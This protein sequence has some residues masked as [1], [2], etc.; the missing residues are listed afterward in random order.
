MLRGSIDA[1]INDHI[2]TRFSAYWM[3]E[4]GWVKNLSTGGTNNG[5]DGW[6]VRGAVSIDITSNLTW[7]VS[8]D[9]VHDVNS[10]IP[11]T[12]VNGDWVSHSA[13]GPVG[14]YVTGEKGTYT[15]NRVWNDTTGFTSKFSLASTIGKISVITGYRHLITKYNLDYFDKNSPLGGYDSIE[16]SEHNQFSQEVNVSGTGL[17]DIVDYTVGAFFFH[18]WNDSDFATLLNLTTPIVP[19]DRT[20]VNTTNSF[21]VYGQFDIHFA[22]KMT[23]T[24]GGRYTADAKHLHYI[25][26]NNPLVAPS[27]HVTDASLLALGIPLNQSAQVFTPRFA[28]QYEPNRD[29][30]FYASATKGFKSGGWNIRAATANLLTNFANETIW[31]Y[32]AGMRSQW[33]DRRVTFNLTGFYGKTK[34]FQIATAGGA[35][36]TGAP[37]FPVGNFSD[38]VSKGIEAELTVKPVHGL[39]LF[40]N[41]GWDWTKYQNPT[42]AVQ[43][44][45]A[46]CLA[47]L[48]YGA[49]VSNA[50]NCGNG[51][52]TAT[53]GI[54]IPLRAPKFTGTVGFTYELALNRDWNLVPTGSW[55][56]VSSFNVNSAQLANTFDPGYDEFFGSI[57]LEN[58]GR[59]LRFSVGCENCTNDN[60]LISVISG[61]K[62]WSPPRRITGRAAIR[63]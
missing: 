28:L 43:A 53:G 10:M 1:P 8:V 5:H 18:E 61:Y 35:M 26:N 22:P 14:S 49:G 55:R 6:G 37:V 11:E 56:H 25:D 40:T 46:A 31:S 54:A 30:T 15:G 41:G 29:L 50:A 12:L 21:A 9:H 2:R 42:P 48:Q 52:V 47:Y 62:Y 36:G 4:D 39:S 32:E 51:I 44:Q 3:D 58:P 20:Y 38:F 16:D 60:Y 23:L 7:D 13:L 63:F 57:G 24:L 59:G 34:N 33:L 17:H 19:Y 27:A 45:Q